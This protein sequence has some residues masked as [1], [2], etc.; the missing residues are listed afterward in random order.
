MIILE[1]EM[2]THSSVLAWRIP[3]TEKPGRLQSVGLHRVGHD[4]S[5]LAA[6]AEDRLV[7]LVMALCFSREWNF[8]L[9]EK[10]QNI[11]KVFGDS[12]RVW[13]VEELVTQVESKG[14]CEDWISGI[15]GLGNSFQL[16]RLTWVKDVMEI[17]GSRAESESCIWEKSETQIGENK[18][19]CRCMSHLMKKFEF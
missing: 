16:G 7:V 13:V 9:E 15:E 6:A 2:A 10:E 18:W 4:G 17:S 3:W 14:R 1:K 12:N 8:T 11:W 19:G 5:N